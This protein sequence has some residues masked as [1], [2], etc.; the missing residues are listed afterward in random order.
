MPAATAAADPP[1]DPPGMRPRSQ[2]LR[3]ILKPE[4]SVEE[5][6][7]NSSML[8]LPTITAPSALSRATTVASYGGTN[9][10]RILEPQVVGT[11]AVHSTSLSA[12]GIPVSGRQLPDAIARSAASACRSASS[13]VTARKASTRGSTAAMRSSTDRVSSREPI[14]RLARRRCASSMLRSCRSTVVLSV[15]CFVFRVWCLAGH[16]ARRHAII[17]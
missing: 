14:S 17:R 15:W 16:D 8:S 13:A 2:G 9:P 4:F 1:L 12:T 3:V 11:P 5:P 10:A 7:A 6:I